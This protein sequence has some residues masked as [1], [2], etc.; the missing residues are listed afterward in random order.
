MSSV[1]SFACLQK[2]AL[3]DASP[4]LNSQLHVHRARMVAQLSVQGEHWKI[5]SLGRG[6]ENL[7]SRDR[8]GQYYSASRDGHQIHPRRMTQIDSVKINPSLVMMREC[9]MFKC[10]NIPMFNWSIG[11][12]VP[13][14]I[15]P[16]VHLSIGPLV[17]WTIG[18]LVHREWASLL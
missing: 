10:S 7:G 3:G 6:L 11:P 12:L 1:T 13:W 4:A 14:S 16:L 15:G 9:Q 8:I 2:F 17:H 18:P 5:L